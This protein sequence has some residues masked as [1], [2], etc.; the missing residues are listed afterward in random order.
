MER[1]R[2]G[3]ADGVGDAHAGIDGFGVIA[4]RIPHRLF[5]RVRDLE[6]RRQRTR[7]AEHLDHDVFRIFIGHARHRHADVGDAGRQQVGTMAG[8]I[9]PALDGVSCQHARLIT[10]AVA[11]QR[12]VLSNLAMLVAR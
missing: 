7:P 11:G 8:R 1:D 12:Q 2:F 6:F 10:T 5:R 3:I 4:Q 9:Q